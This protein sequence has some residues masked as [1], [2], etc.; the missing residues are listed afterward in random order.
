MASLGNSSPV[1]VLAM[2]RHKDSHLLVTHPAKFWDGQVFEAY[3]KSSIMFTKCNIPDEVVA[4]YGH[5]PY[6]ESQL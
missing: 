4:I 2:V 6:A 1:K 3:N 5:C